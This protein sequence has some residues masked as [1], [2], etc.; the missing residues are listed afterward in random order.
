MRTIE[1]N[2]YEAERQ[3]NRIKFGGGYDIEDLWAIISLSPSRNEEW[4]YRGTPDDEID[5]W[6][7]GD[8]TYSIIIENSGWYIVDFD[9]NTIEE[10]TI[11]IDEIIERLI[12]SLKKAFDNDM[13]E[14]NEMTDD[15]E[16]LQFKSW[17]EAA[18]YIKNNTPDEMQ[19]KQIKSRCV[20][21]ER[22]FSSQVADSLIRYGN[23]FIDNKKYGWTIGHNSVGE[24]YFDL[25]L[26]RDFNNIGT[27]TWIIGSTHTNYRILRN[28]FFKTYRQLEKLFLVNSE[29]KNEF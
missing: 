8:T 11:V 5:R 1:I 14:L 3:K 22:W 2:K 7:I 16:K 28:T 13:E 25:R 20:S 4:V 26:N 18:E 12:Y 17:K 10:D 23:E 27:T 19:L 9:G 6:T 24:V 21:D 29:I 15:G